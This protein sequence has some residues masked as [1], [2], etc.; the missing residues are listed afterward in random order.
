MYVVRTA[1]DAV[2]IRK[3]M[4]RGVWHRSRY[5]PKLRKWCVC[6]RA[7]TRRPGWRCGVQASQKESEVKSKTVFQFPSGDVQD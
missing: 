1:V 3:R 6:V 7:C 2:T 4:V 5:E